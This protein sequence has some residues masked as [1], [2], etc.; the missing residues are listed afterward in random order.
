[1]NAGYV[2]DLVRLRAS[3]FDQLALMQSDPHFARSRLPAS[4][5]RTWIGELDD[6]IGGNP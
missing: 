2:Q 3:L 6:I 1:M 4:V 5:I